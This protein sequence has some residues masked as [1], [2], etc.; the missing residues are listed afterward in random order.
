MRTRTP[1]IVRVLCGAAWAALFVIRVQA[2]TPNPAP[3]QNQETAA[4][5]SFRASTNLVVIPVSVT[6]ASNRFVLG[7]RQG[8]FQVLDDGVE[9]S[10]A[11]F[12]GEDAPLSI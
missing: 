11:H 9:Q 2:Q 7:L 1:Y 3:N 6:D 12:S 8:E 5:P 4:E 10:I